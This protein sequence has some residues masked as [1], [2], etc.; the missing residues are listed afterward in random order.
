MDF[1]ALFFN[2]QN[3]LIFSRKYEISLFSFFWNKCEVF[4][5]TIRNYTQGYVPTDLILIWATNDPDWL[6]NEKEIGFSE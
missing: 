1:E 6:K 5:K 3:S 4:S 2:F